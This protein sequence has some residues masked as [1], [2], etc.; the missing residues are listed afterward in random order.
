MNRKTLL[1]LGV[2]ALIASPS[3]L[4]LGCGGCSQLSSRD[5]TGTAAGEWTLT[6]GAER[7]YA[8]LALEDALCR[9]DTAQM[10]EALENLKTQTLPAATYAEAAAFLASRKSEKTAGLIAAGLS[11]YP[12]DAALNLLRAEQLLEAGDTS[13]GMAHMRRYLEKHPASTDAR[14]SLALLLL[15][16]RKAQEAETLL[17]GIPAS[18]RTAVVE[19]CHARAL[20]ALGQEEQAM[21]HLRRALQL[22]P[23][24]VE[25]VTDLADLHEQRQEWAA[26]RDLYE[27]ARTLRGESPE[28]LLRIMRAELKLNRESAALRMAKQGPATAEFAL[29]AAGVFMEARRYGAAEAVLTTLKDQQDAPEEIPLLLAELVYRQHRDAAAALHWLDNIPATAACRPHA[30]LLRLQ[31]LHDQGRKEDALML[32]RTARGEYP[33]MAEFALAEIRILA[34]SRAFQEARHIAE[35]SSAQWPDNT[36]LLFL[37]ASLDDQLGDKAR[38]MQGMERILQKAPEHY[39]ALNYVGYTLAEQ[40]RDLPRALRLLGKAVE[41]SPDSAYIWDSLAWAQFR[42]GDVAGAWKSIRRAV[43]LDKNAE[44]AVWEHYGDIAAALGHKAEAR[45]GY[46]NALDGKPE[47]AVTLQR[48]LSDL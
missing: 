10:E 33:D 16:N 25:A 6:P 12:D 44:P 24:F 11:H 21:R 30:T 18:E 41:L 39:Q 3:L 36:E 8:V 5:S 27:Q 32:A 42:A 47:N 7:I 2:A 1:A 28:L 40:N 34:G 19:R 31:I 17:R 38:A 9:E 35:A 23:D 46:G 45:K 14:L 26:A 48:K 22:T 4:L 29:T 37:L 15:R 13:E 20:A 43:D